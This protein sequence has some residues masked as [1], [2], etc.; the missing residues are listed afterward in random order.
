M[1]AFRIASPVTRL[2]SVA[3]RSN[4]CKHRYRAVVRDSIGSLSA[5]DTGTGLWF[6]IFL[7]ASEHLIR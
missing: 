1:I 6:G 4:H 5:R 7:T 2:G 3:F